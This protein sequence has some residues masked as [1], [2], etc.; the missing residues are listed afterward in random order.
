M[1]LFKNFELHR[2]SPNVFTTFAKNG[3]RI[4]GHSETRGSVQRKVP[5][6]P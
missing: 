6:L 2:A 3:P 1:E 4:P 5:P